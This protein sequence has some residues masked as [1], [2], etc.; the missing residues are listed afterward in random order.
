VSFNQN[1]CPVILEKGFEG[2]ALEVSIGV[3]QQEH[4]SCVRKALK[5]RLERLAFASY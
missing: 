2:E 5:E 1:I 4:V 3:L